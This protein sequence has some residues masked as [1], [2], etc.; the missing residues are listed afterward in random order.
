M[1]NQLLRSSAIVLALLGSLAASAQERSQ[2]PGNVQDVGKPADT[3]PKGPLPGPNATPP[4]ANPQPAAV[5]PDK[6]VQPVPGAMPGSATVPS[7]LSDKN[8]ADDKLI[9]TAYTFKNLSAEEQQ[10][11]YQALKDKPAGSSFNADIGT[12]LPHAIELHA[13]PNDIVTRVPQTKGYRF[14]VA[15]NRVLLVSPADRVVVGVFP[16]GKAME[17]TGGRRSPQ[18]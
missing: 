10:A 13:M 3:A 9:T 15:D 1:R 11:I 7:T 18:Q 12:E 2:Q 8:A 6:S 4:A 16:E 14:A 5:A 17:T